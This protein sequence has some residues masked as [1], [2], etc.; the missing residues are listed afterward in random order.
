MRERIKI[1]LLQN[2]LKAVTKKYD[3]FIEQQKELLKITYRKATR[4][5]LTGL[6]N[7]QFLLDY[8]E[9]AIEK[10]IRNNS[11]ASLIFI[12]LDNFKCI[13][14]SFGHDIGDKILVNFANLLRKYFR[15]YDIIARLGGDEFVVFTELNNLHI[16][17]ERLDKIRKD[18]ESEPILRK[19]NLSFSY[20]ITLIPDEAKNIKEIIELADQRMYNQ[21]HRKK[22]NN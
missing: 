20:G 14:D 15:K 21:K 17:N 8:L 16:L 13:N 22:T 5:P 2:M 6:Y 7:R 4:D 1:R 11:K 9:K 12:D 18:F 10:A 3:E 19:C